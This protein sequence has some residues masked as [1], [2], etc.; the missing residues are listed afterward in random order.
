MANY[1]LLRIMIGEKKR[2]NGEI[3]Y[4]H[5]VKYLMKNKIAG[6]SVVRGIMGYGSSFKIHS[7]SFLTLSEDLPI[8]IEVVDK[9]EK[10]EE[11]IPKLK[12]MLDGKGLMTLEKVE[13]IHPEI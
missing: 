11:V 12:K 4:K 10:L 9:R 2:I 1:Q 3:G 13:V 8:I 5:I 6:A 7:L